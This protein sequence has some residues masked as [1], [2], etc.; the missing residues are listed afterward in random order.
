MTTILTGL[1]G[2][3]QAHSAIT[4]PQEHW[5]ISWFNKHLTDSIYG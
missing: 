2:M 1:L 4:V 5:T 3:V